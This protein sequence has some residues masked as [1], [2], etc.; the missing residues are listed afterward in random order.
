MIPM[1]I[2]LIQFKGSAQLNQGLYQMA[3]ES[4]TKA[5]ELDPYSAVI[6]VYRSTAR[7]ELQL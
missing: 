2:I 5:M 7:I 1:F 6:P 3:V 4:Y